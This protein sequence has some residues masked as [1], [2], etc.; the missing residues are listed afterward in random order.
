M[1]ERANNWR[2]RIELW[3]RPKEKLED[4]P[5]DGFEP[6]R[7]YSMQQA[8]DL[9]ENLFRASLTSEPPT[10]DPLMTPSL[11]RIKSSASTMVV[12]C[13]GLAGSGVTQ[14]LA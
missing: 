12:G 7:E 4:C 1:V 13:F 2:V 3:L 11:H 6:T 14:K 8:I 10:N 9:S 5:E